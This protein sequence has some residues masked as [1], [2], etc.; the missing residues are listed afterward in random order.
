[1]EL[2]GALKK[3]HPDLYKKAYVEKD[4]T[5]RKKMIATL[6]NSLASLQGRVEA[7]ESEA[8]K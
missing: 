4:P 3:E 1:M 6:A 2:C 7:L 8:R 5:V